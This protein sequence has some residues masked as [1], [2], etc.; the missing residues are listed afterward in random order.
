VRDVGG[1]DEFT[2]DT[3]GEELKEVASVTVGA[4]VGEAVSES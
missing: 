3:D 1:S 2:D 4:A